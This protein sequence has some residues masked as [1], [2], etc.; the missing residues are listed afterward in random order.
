MVTPNAPRPLLDRIALR[1]PPF[2]VDQAATR[3]AKLPPGSPLRR[4]VLKRFMRR[5]FDAHARKD[6][7]I[8]QLIYEPDVELSLSGAEGLGLAE[9]YSGHEGWHDLIGDLYESFAEPRYTVKRV[10]DG[11]DRLVFEF[12][13]AAMGNTSAAPVTLSVGTVMFFSPR[14]KVERQHLFWQDGWRQALE[15]AGLSE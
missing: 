11:G 3:F 12:E 5:S 8:A 15:A 1:I 6:V 9:R 10:L 13:F 7:E 4:R 2:L 14:G